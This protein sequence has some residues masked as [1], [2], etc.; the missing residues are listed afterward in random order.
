MK[1]LTSGRI[2]RRRF[3]KSAAALSAAALACVASLTGAAAGDPVDPL[4]EPQLFLDDWL[5]AEM[6]GL[7]RTLHQPKKHGL[8]QEADG[9]DWDRGDVYHGSIVCRDGR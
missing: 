2:G 8:I 5:I 3:M 9:R 6:K 1:H 7:R 4:K